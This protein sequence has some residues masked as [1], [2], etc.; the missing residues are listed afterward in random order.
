M[1]KIQLKLKWLSFTQ[2]Y[3][4]FYTSVNKKTLVDLLPTRQRYRN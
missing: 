4:P 3:E 1:N 2:S